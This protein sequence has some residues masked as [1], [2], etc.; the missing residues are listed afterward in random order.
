MPGAPLS[1]RLMHP[2]I[3]ACSDSPSKIPFLIASPMQSFAMPCQTFSDAARCQSSGVL[4]MPGSVDHASSDEGNAI[5]Y[6][7]LV[8]N[9]AV[10]GQTDSDWPFASILLCAVR[11]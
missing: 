4:G 11:L 9:T 1:K 5:D 10:F 8:V 6:V 2:E 7:E 3:S